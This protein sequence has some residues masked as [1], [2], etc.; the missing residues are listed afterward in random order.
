[1]SSIPH[2]PNDELQFVGV[3]P[4][5]PTLGSIA[6]ATSS[7]AAASEECVTSSA[8]PSMGDLHNDL[9]PRTL[10][11]P[12]QKEIQHPG[13]IPLRTV[14]LLQI[15]CLR[16]HVIVNQRDRC[17][18][19]NNFYEECLCD[20]GIMR[21]YMKYSGDSPGSTFRKMVYAGIKGDAEKYAAAGASGMDPTELEI[22]SS[23]I[24]TQRDAALATHAAAAAAAKKNK[25]A[26]ER[27]QSEAAEEQLGL[28]GGPGLV[29]PSP[30]TRLLGSNPSS[31]FGGGS[32]SSGR[33]GSR[34]PGEISLR[35]MYSLFT[36]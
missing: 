28:R 21:Q 31:L 17:A 32:S 33:A 13:F 19:W 27:A 5:A 9:V 11:L 25:E 12:T 18:A 3:V 1:M 36:F 24:I 20:H 15:V 6:T 34:T 35:V 26:R 22:N 29:S 16:I 30:T 14:L 23:I 10:K 7:G 2:L 4:A 8:A